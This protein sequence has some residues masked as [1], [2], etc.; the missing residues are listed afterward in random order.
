MNPENA[1]AVQGTSAP[2]SEIGTSTSTDDV[3]HDKKKAKQRILR[4]IADANSNSFVHI[5]LFNS[6]FDTGDGGAGVERLLR[7]H[8]NLM[9]V[10]GFLA[11]LQFL[12]L[13]GTNDGRTQDDIPPREQL[14]VAFQVAGFAMSVTGTFVSFIAT[15]FFNGVASEHAEMQVEGILRWY[16]FFRC[17]E[18]LGGTTCVMLALATN[19]IVYD[20]L[21]RWVCVYTNAVT[22]VAGLGFLVLFKKII[23]NKHTYA[24]GRK[25][26]IYRDAPSELLQVRQ[27]PDPRTNGEDLTS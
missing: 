12:A 1:A 13:G 20:K 19:V 10:H 21:P 24:G 17:S 26:Y 3:V 9:S 27:Q 25:L 8:V 2:P 11:G 5:L 6:F 18:I 14:V 7:I 23:V 4:R 22:L 15:V 16:A